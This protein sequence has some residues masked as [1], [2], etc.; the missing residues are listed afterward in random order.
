VINEFQGLDLVSKS[1]APV[2]TQMFIPDSFAF[3]SVW[4]YMGV[5]LLITCANLVISVA[6][7]LVV[8]RFRKNL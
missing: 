7:T 4:S 2:P 3:T 5:V 8:V 6:T 1:G